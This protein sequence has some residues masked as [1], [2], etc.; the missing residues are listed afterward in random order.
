MTLF[1]C[2]FIQQLNLQ[3]KRLYRT[4]GSGSN[5]YAFFMQH[6]KTYNKGH[7]LASSYA[8]HRA[9][10]CREALSQPFTLLNG[11]T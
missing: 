2:K 8:M 7:L 6:S 11:K 9:L 1:F 10:H 4:F 3:V 5:H